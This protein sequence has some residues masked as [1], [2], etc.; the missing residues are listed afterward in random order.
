MSVHFPAP[1]LHS[2]FFA[3]E[4]TDE[5]APGY[6]DVVARPIA[7]KTIQQRL[8]AAEYSCQAELFGDFELMV[9]NCRLFNEPHAKDFPVRWAACPAAVVVLLVA[10]YW[11]PCELMWFAWHQLCTSVQSS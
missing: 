7:L 2:K 5:E 1:H 6:S 4:P 8:L 10:I 9:A 11:W 3:T